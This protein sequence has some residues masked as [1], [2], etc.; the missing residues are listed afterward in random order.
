MRIVIMKYLLILFLL[1]ICFSCKREAQPIIHVDIKPFEKQINSGNAFTQE[2]VNKIM[3]NLQS[4]IKKNTVRKSLPSVNLV[5]VHGTNVD[6]VDL[7]KKRSIIIFTDS[8]CGFGKGSTTEDFPEV[9]NKLQKR[10]R[11]FDVFCIVI[12]SNSDSSDTKSF[13]SFISELKPIYPNLYLI[14]QTDSQRLNIYGVPTHFLVDNNKIVVSYRTGMAM[15]PN[16][17][18]D[19][20]DKFLTNYK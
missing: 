11:D 4:E 3:S 8:H 18:Y 15:V 6:L 14:N 20:V 13:D 5:N 9:L 2:D 1:I 7:I 19:E 10:H 16:L 12:N 17:L